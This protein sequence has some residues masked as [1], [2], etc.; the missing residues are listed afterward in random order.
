MKRFYKTAT[1]GADAGDAPGFQ[2]L[3]DGR[4]VRTPAKAPLVVLSQPL[5][6]AIAEEWQAQDEEVDPALMPLN[7]L[8]CTAI[9]IVVPQRDRIVA[10]LA[11]YGGHDLICYWTDEVGELLGLQQQHWQPLLDWAADRFA[12]PLLKTGGVVSQE[13]PAASLAA[14]KQAVA[15]HQ[16]MALTGLAAA[17]QAAGSLIIGLA[18]SHG[19]LDADQAHAVSQLDDTYQARRWGEDAEAA[20]RRENLRQE[21][22][23]AERF[24]E[25]LRCGEGVAA[26]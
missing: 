19:R 25:L 9:D 6:Q 12:A 11:D 18:L 3:L 16:G 1:A 21:L 5:A 10:D 26:S 13:Q 23:S 14:L 8:T 22:L 17:V 2:V 15:D 4:P 20:A 7:S 24:L